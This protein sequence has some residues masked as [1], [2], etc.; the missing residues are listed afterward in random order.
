MNATE[1]K[2]SCQHCSEHIAF[3]PHFAGQMTTCPHCQMETRLFIPTRAP[4]RAVQSGTTESVTGWIAAAYIC[5]FLFPLLGLLLGVN[6]FSKRQPAHAIV[7]IVLSL[8]SG[9]IA[10]EVFWGGNGQ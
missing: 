4:S 1:A 8:L 7:S 3:E 5:A 6:L 2:C 10:Y 9:V